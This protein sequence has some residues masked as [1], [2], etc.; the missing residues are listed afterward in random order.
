MHFPKNKQN[1]FCSMLTRVSVQFSV[2]TIFLIHS[3][4][5]L[6]RECIVTQGKRSSER[7]KQRMNGRRLCRRP[8]ICLHSSVSNQTGANIVLLL[9]YIFFAAFFMHSE[10]VAAGCWLLCYMCAWNSLCLFW[11]GECLHVLCIVLRCQQAEGTHKEE[12]WTTTHRTENSSSIV[13]RMAENRKQ[14][15]RRRGNGLYALSF[16]HSR[17]FR[18]MCWM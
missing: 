3:L 7:K 18:C 14:R 4:C 11:I 13:L 1:T 10:C 8:C 2:L 16:R 12:R 5:C 6:V 15:E 9:L 17:E